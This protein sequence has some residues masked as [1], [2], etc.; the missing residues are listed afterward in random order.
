MLNFHGPLDQSTFFLQSQL[1][2][3]TWSTL[4]H[5]AEPD[6]QQGVW[7]A[8]PR[9]VI[10]LDTKKL[11]WFKY[12]MGDKIKRASECQGGGFSRSKVTRKRS[13]WS[14]I[15][16]EAIQRAEPANHTGNEI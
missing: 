4:L 14:P 5:P 6:S 2:P 3:D 7:V 13:G 11:T 16:N 10:T 15:I 1:L 9:P 12:K 8:S